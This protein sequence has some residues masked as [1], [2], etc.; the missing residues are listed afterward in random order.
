MLAMLAIAVQ[1]L[2]LQPHV[3]A[4]APAEHYVASVSAHSDTTPAALSACAV[5][6][7]AASARVFTAP[8]Q[9][10]LPLL[11]RVIAQA[12]LYADQS[13]TLTLT[14]A[15]RSRAPPPSLR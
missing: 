8:P 11:T 13:V 14:P 4:I 15:W 7:S 9:V 6:H 5:C 2:V 3:H 1:T 10:V 12:A